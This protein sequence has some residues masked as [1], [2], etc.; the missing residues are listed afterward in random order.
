MYGGRVPCS[1]F[2]IWSEYHM[3]GRSTRCQPCRALARWPTLVY[4]RYAVFTQGF[5]CTLQ[6]ICTLGSSRTDYLVPPDPQLR[7]APLS[8]GSQ[9]RCWSPPRPWSGAA[10]TPHSV[11]ASTV[12]LP[13]ICAGSAYVHR[14]GRTWQN[15]SVPQCPPCPACPA[16]WLC[17]HAAPHAQIENKK[18]QQEVACHNLPRFQRIC[19]AACGYDAHSVWQGV[20]NRR[21]TTRPK[22]ALHR[23][24]SPYTANRRTHSPSL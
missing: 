17:M 11:F 12:C 5:L 20:C 2:R 4:I 21:L 9:C 19:H 15:G 6:I 22:D 7:I 24:R 23:T 18:C 3:Q 13:Q 14:A 1:V 16:H 10:S 8:A